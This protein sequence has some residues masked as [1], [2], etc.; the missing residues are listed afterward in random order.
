MKLESV[1]R[2]WSKVD[3]SGG[4]RR[5][6]PWTGARSGNGYGAFKDQGKQYQAHRLAY[7]ISAGESLG[8]RYACHRC[9]NPICCNP[10]HLFAGTALDN[11]RDRDSKGRQSTGD[12]VPYSRR[13]R[14]SRHPSA[15]LSEAVVLEIRG[16]L[17]EGERQI[18]VARRLG[19]NRQTIHRIAHGRTWKHVD[20]A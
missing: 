20:A 18:D 14:G 10:T 1:E 5:C 16:A 13:A 12:R 8:S 4:E 9:D 3:Q 7:E 2:F 15:V 6:W 17:R 11:V 19:V